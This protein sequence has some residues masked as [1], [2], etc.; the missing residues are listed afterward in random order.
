MP[1]SRKAAVVRYE[2]TVVDITERKQLDEWR[3]QKEAADAANHAK[4]AFLARVSHEIRTPLNGVIGMLEVLSGTEMSDRQQQ[5]LR[6]ARTS[7][8]SLLG[9]MNDLLDF[10]KIEAGKLELERAPF[11]IRSIATEV[12]EAFGPAAAGKSLALN[13]SIASEVPACVLGDPER[14]RQI[15][16]NLVNNAIKFTEAGA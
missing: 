11:S 2:G 15:L 1:S 4:S 5:Q 13:C 8:L 6:I 3:R 14:V 12:T 16:V 10:S 9:L 7:A